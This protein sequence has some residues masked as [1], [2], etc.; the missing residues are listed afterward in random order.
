MIGPDCLIVTKGGGKFKSPS[1]SSKRDP[2]AREKLSE[3]GKSTNISPPC[4][5][6]SRPLIA[7]IA[8]GMR[9]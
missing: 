4:L 9:R 5:K 3:E 6:E 1:L 7:S 8:G 2:C